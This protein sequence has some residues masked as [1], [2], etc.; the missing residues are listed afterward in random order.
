[1]AGEFLVITG[2]GDV[3]SA[4]E[5][6]RAPSTCSSRTPGRA[7]YLTVPVAGGMLPMPSVVDY[8]APASDEEASA[9]ARQRLEQ[10]VADLAVLGAQV[11]GGLRVGRRFG[12]P[13]TTI[14]SER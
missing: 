12:L 2:E 1:M 9:Q 14:I 11:E 3:Y 4:H 13:V 7:H 10:T 6:V 8:D 5:V